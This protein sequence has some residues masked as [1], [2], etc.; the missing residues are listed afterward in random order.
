MLQEQV[1]LSLCALTL[2]SGWKLE[3][4]NMSPALSRT[5][6]NWGMAAALCSLWCFNLSFYLVHVT[7]EMKKRHGFQ[8]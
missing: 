4:S 7:C 8:Y 3:M 5:Q 2:E 6:P 1:T